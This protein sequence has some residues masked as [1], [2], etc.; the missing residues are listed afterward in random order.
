MSYDISKPSK[1]VGKNMSMDSIKLAEIV[2]MQMKTLKMA[3][4]YDARSVFVF[5]LLL[6]FHT[7]VNFFFSQLHQACRPVQ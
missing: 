5:Y 7:A 3:Y 2:M 6:C 4:L 1:Y